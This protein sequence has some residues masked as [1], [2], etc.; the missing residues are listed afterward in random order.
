MNMKKNIPEKSKILIKN[1]DILEINKVF[2]SA[3]LKSLWNFQKQCIIY[4]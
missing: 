4:Y 2:L 3:L 1:L